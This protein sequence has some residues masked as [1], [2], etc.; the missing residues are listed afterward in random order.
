LEYG[1]NNKYGHPNDLVLQRLENLKSKIYR[2]DLNGE[3]TLYI[4]K[5]GNIKLR[6]HV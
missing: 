4:E 3:I 5:N 1:E 6:K 2:T